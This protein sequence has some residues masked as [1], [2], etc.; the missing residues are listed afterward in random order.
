MRI[1][2]GKTTLLI[3]SVRSSRF[4]RG[5][6]LYGRGH[7][8]ILVRNDIRRNRGPLYSRQLTIRSLS[9]LADRCLPAYDFEKGTRFSPQNIAANVPLVGKRIGRLTL[10]A[11]KKH[12][13]ST[14]V[15]ELHEGN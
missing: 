10:I 5:T 6:S 3:E 12:S 1:Q 8:E 4:F 7:R 2:H 14:R 13:F 15:D 11:I 9:V